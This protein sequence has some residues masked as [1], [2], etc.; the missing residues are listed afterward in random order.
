MMGRV[1]G[2]DVMGRRPSPALSRD[3][4]RMRAVSGGVRLG[5]AHYVM[6]PLS[7]SRR[8]STSLPCSRSGEPGRGERRRAQWRR[9][10]RK[11][12]PCRA[13]RACRRGNGACEHF[14]FYSRPRDRVRQDAGTCGD[15]LSDPTRHAK[16]SRP[17]RPGRRRGWLGAKSDGCGNGWEWELGQ[18]QKGERT[19]GRTI[20]E[21]NEVAMWGGREQAESSR[22]ESLPGRRRRGTTKQQ[23]HRPGWP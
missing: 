16:A 8:R 18:G 7:T 10:R 14:D 6:S 13:L 5:G 9:S 15:G 23:P 19:D 12:A 11:Q 17:S 22:A 21:K 20:V 4:T 2:G 3:G 1:M